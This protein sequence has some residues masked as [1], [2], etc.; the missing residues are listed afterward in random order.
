MYRAGKAGIEGAGDTVLGTELCRAQ[1]DSELDAEWGP[2]DATAGDVTLLP[3]R[4]N[5]RD[6][7]LRREVG[8][9]V[10]GVVREGSRR[11]GSQY[12]QPRNEGTFEKNRDTTNVFT[13]A[14]LSDLPGNGSQRRL[15]LLGCSGRLSEIGRHCNGRLQQSDASKRRAM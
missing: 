2:A 5:R 6:E 11:L 7:K 9:E 8:G 4:E 14:L 13:T 12:T 3:C 1:T 10:T 15:T